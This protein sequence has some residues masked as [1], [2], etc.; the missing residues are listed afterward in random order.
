[1]EI[2]FV[3][4]PLVVLI[5]SILGYV[6]FVKVK[7]VEERLR[8]VE[9]KLRQS[10]F[11][12]TA[13]AVSSR[14]VDPGSV[15]SP[16]PAEVLPKE[17]TSES[18]WSADVN[19]DDLSD[20]TYTLDSAQE[21]EPLTPEKLA[22]D[23]MALIQ[24]YWM[25]LLG[26]VCLVFSGIF[27]VRYSIEN[28]MLG[29]TARLSLG[30]VFG[31][32]LILAGEK[33][34]WNGR[35]E[36]GVHAVFVASGSLVIYSALLVGFHYYELISAQAAFFGMALMS[37]LSMLLALKHGPMMAGMGLLG[38]YLVPIL[39]ST[40]SNNIEAALLYSFIVTCSSLWL[41]RYIYRDWLWWG[42]WVGAIGWFILSLDLPEMGQGARALYLAALAY[43]G[44]ALSFSGLKLG[45]IDADLLPGRDI[46]EQITVLFSALAVS[47]AVLLHIENL[48][49]LSYPAVVLLPIVA[50]LVARNN[51]PL[52]R[53]MPVIALMPIIAE[54]FTMDVSF[55]DWK[56]TI[57]PMAEHLQ[58]AYITMLA[59]VTVAF[60]GIGGKEFVKVRHPGYWV[61][62]I[63]FMPLIAIVLAYLR[64]SGMQVG[65]PWAL[66]TFVLAGMYAYLLT[67]CRNKKQSVEVE[68][69]FAI[70][71]QAAIAIGCFFV[72]S[73]VTLTLI[74]AVQLI[75]LAYIDRK[76]HVAVLPVIMKVMLLLVI[77]RLTFNPWVALYEVSSLTLLLTYIG[78]LAS[79]VVASR[80]VQGRAKLVI[81]LNTASAH[82]LVL[83]L[84]VFTR[85]MLYGGDIFAKEFNLTEASVYVCSWAA[86]GI[87]YEWKS[88][89]LEH[90]KKWYRGLAMLH[91]YA[92]A[93]LY[94]LYNLL[95]HNPL[96]HSESI[97]SVPIF[98]VLLVGYG[99]PV[100]LAAVVYKRIED[101]KKIAGLI[102]MIGLYMFVTLEIRH[103]W[104]G[105]IPLNAPVKEGELYTYS[106]VWLL[107]SVMIMVLGAYKNNS[108]AKKAGVVAL[109]VVVAKAFFWDM[110][111]L[112]GLWRVVSFLGLGLS[113]L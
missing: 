25:V 95:L 90:F 99:I 28:G 19:E 18:K 58:S 84:A 111:D 105:G 103:L 10:Q 72:F 47:L 77:V 100:V 81:W 82:L 37:A 109:L 60:A 52:L 80:E 85:Y 31:A 39:V 110:R 26:G 69:A 45:K 66:P 42:T 83:T 7:N 6:S 13:S 57:E 70:A 3:I 8:F 112:D 75:G 76:I 97:G 16:A 64:V 74:L 94:V 44:V 91:I 93:G 61:S 98:N 11:D 30:L 24:Q 71:S 79:C 36:A 9:R 33:L 62:F 92:A 86:V 51:L 22:I 55:S 12:Q 23:W 29:P 40:G 43:A 54:L 27:L 38:A 104:N 53:L 87:I 48:N 102:S 5:G 63:L 67:V 32:C 113:L 56:I 14:R 50:A 106:L 101:L 34:R 78:C 89:N 4:I 46:L 1:M 73:E 2:L 21:E 49:E 15:S 41:Q 65:L 107:I 35:L 17:K 108:D 88:N 59:L 96:W 68:A 20:L